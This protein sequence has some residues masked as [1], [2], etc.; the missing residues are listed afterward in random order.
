MILLGGNWWKQ[1]VSPEV[2]NSSTRE[3]LTWIGI[4]EK[5]EGKKRDWEGNKR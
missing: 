1:N 2:L 4:G 3:W 5:V